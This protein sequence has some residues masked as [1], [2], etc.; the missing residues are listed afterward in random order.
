MKY[1]LFIITDEKEAILE[2][3]NEQYYMFKPPYKTCEKISY[4]DYFKKVYG[5]GG[6]LY[7]QNLP[8]HSQV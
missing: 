4:V 8:L 5:G 1:K 3:E 6:E 7:F 2:D